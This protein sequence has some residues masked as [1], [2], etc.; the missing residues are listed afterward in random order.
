MPLP[1]FNRGLSNAAIGEHR[2]A[3]NDFTEVIKREPQ[4]TDAYN[5]R[6]LSHA[7]LG[8]DEQAIA[9]FSESIRLDPSFV[10]A[11]YN[12]GT[13]YASLGKYQNSIDDYTSAIK[14]D[15][16]YATA[17]NN[18]GLSYAQIGKHQKA[19][20]DFNKA[21]EL[22]PETTDAYENR[23]ISNVLLKN[24]EEAKADFDRRNSALNLSLLDAFKE[25]NEIHESYIEGLRAQ[26]DREDQ[27]YYIR[28]EIDARTKNLG[29][30]KEER[31]QALC[32]LKVVSTLTA[33]VAVCIL[34][35]LLTHKEVGNAWGVLSISLLAIAVISPYAWA[36]RLT[37][38][39]FTIAEALLES[40]RAKEEVILRIDRAV[41]DAESEEERKL[42]NNR[43]IEFLAELRLANLLLTKDSKAVS[44]TDQRW[45]INMPKVNDK[46]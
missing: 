39:D 30:L 25:R 9:D 21:I 26:F 27:S 14:V 42:L 15:E 33:L 36:V 17:Y 18:R 46:E 22:D 44:A 10:L 34:I 40:F 35:N 16:R 5:N 20:D 4:N 29:T 1:R 6:G 28:R 8:E 12:R 24:Y 32:W 45:N 3:I 2:K 19:V 43:R 31:N 13:S 41:G 7:A 37:Q 23:G 38:N 11:Y